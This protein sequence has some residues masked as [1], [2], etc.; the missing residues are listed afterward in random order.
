MAFEKQIQQAKDVAQHPFFGF[1]LWEVA[2]VVAMGYFG[3]KAY[4]S[5]NDAAQ[6]SAQGDK[7]GTDKATQQAILLYGAMIPGGVFSSTDNDTLLSTG[8]QITNFAAVKDAYQNLYPGRSLASDLSTYVTDAIKAQFLQEISDA[9]VNQGTM[10]INQEAAK[11]YGILHSIVP[12][13]DAQENQLMQLANDINNSGASNPQAVYNN[14]ATAYKAKYGADLNIDLHNF[15]VA[16]DPD[17]ANA[18][19]DDFMNVVTGA[20]V[21]VEPEDYRDIYH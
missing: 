3:Y 1:Q 5:A 12:V 7:V 21:I 8:K 6:Q 16:Y 9:N 18:H 13:N 10:D 4:K 20:A 19:D 15:W 17:F 2:A 11:F 14:I